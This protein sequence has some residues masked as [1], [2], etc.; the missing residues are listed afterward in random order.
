[1]DRRSL[2]K[3]LAGAIVAGPFSGTAAIP[4]H[5]VM[6]ASMDS[7]SEEIPEQLC[8]VVVTNSV[9][10][11]HALLELL[12]LMGW[13]DNEINLLSFSLAAAYCETNSIEIAGVTVDGSP[14][15]AI[16]TICHQTGLMVMAEADGTIAVADRYLDAAGAPCYRVRPTPR[17]LPRIE[18]IA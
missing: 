15:D 7:V 10:P 4:L 9:N 17:R 1:M 18:D 8:E 14:N 2:L 11:A 5:C 3:T 13:R 6:D 16:Q 12:R